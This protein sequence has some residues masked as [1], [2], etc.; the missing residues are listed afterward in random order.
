ML[1]NKRIV[2]EISKADELI[3]TI[4][5]NLI[6]LEFGSLDRG[7]LT[8]VVDWGIYVNRG[9]LSFVDRAG[10][11]NYKNANNLDLIRYTVRF[12]LAYGDA[13]TLIA[14]FK[15]E[16]A[17]LDEETNVV[18]IQC[19]SSLGELQ[20]LKQ[21]R[22]FY[23][24][25]KRSLKRLLEGDYNYLEGALLH[26]NGEYLLNY[27]EDTASL[28]NTYIYCPY[29]PIETLWFNLTKI[30][31]AS[32]NRVIEDEEGT[33]VITGSFPERTPIVITPQ[34]IIDIPTSDFVRVVN[35]SITT[36]N[37]E[38]R[39]QSNSETIYDFTLENVSA[40]I[41]INYDKQG[42]PLSSSADETSFDTTDPSN[43]KVTI[44]K[45]V[46]TPY[47]I[48][49]NGTSR[50][51]VGTI[52]TSNMEIIDSGASYSSEHWGSQYVSGDFSKILINQT[53]TIKRV[54]DGVPLDRLRYIDFK[55]YGDHFVDNGTTDLQ[56]ISDETK[57]VLQIP[58]NDLI[59][60]ESYFDNGDGSITSLSQ[61][62]LQEVSRRY[63]KG[64]E[65]FE[66]ECLFNNYYYEDGTQAFDREDLSNHFK[67]YD[68]IIP[69]VQRGGQTVPLRTN[70]NGEPKKFR[71]IGI[72]YSYDGLLRQKLQVQE[73]RYD[74]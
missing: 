50:R 16:S 9:S 22:I 17:T 14:T 21:K 13:K 54:Y 57:D 8:N 69:Y 46:D 61:H 37:R 68:V 28:D 36:T 15:T 70:E 34:N 3:M 66:I 33:A 58:S 25:A 42:H 2:V 24:F 73:E 52:E 11:F 35:S 27:G 1:Q 59:Q 31:Q 74:L 4:D 67:K 20:R 41:T 44:K 45:T 47:K 43:I 7:S 39:A 53:Y 12:Y 60:S 5:Q 72:S 19:I 62:I 55:F 6:S 32:M 38:K 65:C 18:T 48:W 56:N 63:G 30:C 51:F 71:I 23:P 64:I 29:F 49:G 40:R 26:Q 10:L